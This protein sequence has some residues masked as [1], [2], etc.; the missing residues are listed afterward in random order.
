MPIKKTLERLQDEGSGPYLIVFRERGKTESE[1]KVYFM[2]NL[3]SYFEDISYLLGPP[4]Y[5]EMIVF[6]VNLKPIFTV[7]PISRNK[8]NEVWLLTFYDSARD[9]LIV[10]RR[11]VKEALVISVD[12]EVTEEFGREAYKRLKEVLGL[13]LVKEMNL[14]EPEKIAMWEQEN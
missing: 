2:E 13:S 9:C 8:A 6:E 10:G 3:T 1:H 12:R 7:K 4:Y 14:F 5:Y 11:N